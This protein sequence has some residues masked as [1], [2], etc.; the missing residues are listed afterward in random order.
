MVPP[1]ING[2]KYMGNLGCF[3]IIGVISP[4]KTHLDVPPRM[5]GKGRVT[6]IPRAPFR[7]LCFHE[8]GESRCSK[9]IFRLTYRVQ[10]VDH[11]TCNKTLR[12]VF[13][14]SFGGVGNGSLDVRAWVC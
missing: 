7:P 1:P 6:R 13:C 2:R 5:H 10:E 4:Y 8:C 11:A 12:E 3:I 9:H 14:N